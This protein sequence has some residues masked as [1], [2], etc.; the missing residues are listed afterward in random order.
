LSKIADPSSETR[1]EFSESAA[2]FSETLGK[3]S[4]IRTKFSEIRGKFS[5]IRSRPSNT[6]GELSEIVF[7]LSETLGKFSEHVSKV[8]PN[9]FQLP[10]IVSQRSE[11]VSKSSERGSKFSADRFQLPAIAFQ[12]SEN[13]SKF[14]GT[15]GELS[16]NIFQLSHVLGE[17]SPDRRQLAPDRR[18][19]SHVVSRLADNVT[20]IAPAFSLRNPVRFRFAANA[21]TRREGGLV[22]A[23]RRDGVA[24]H[25]C[26]GGATLLSAMKQLLELPRGVERLEL[27][28]AA[29][30]LVVDEDLGN[31]ALSRRGSGFLSNRRESQHATR[32][33]RDP[34]R[35]S[36]E[37]RRRPPSSRSRCRLMV[38]TTPLAA[39]RSDEGSANS[40]AVDAEALVHLRHSPRPR[41]TTSTGRLALLY[42]RDARWDSHRRPELISRWLHGGGDGIARH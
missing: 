8:S 10:A 32:A 40:W 14:E 38:R 28:G 42:R 19:L 29:D 4:E 13:V 24:E 18:R 26:H 3:F 12:L 16:E 34:R 36:R 27:V 5:P 6:L 17:L 1:T 9:R 35:I 11:N 33:P 30:R 37:A 20:E 7:R 25:R 22:I 23:H 41:S 2:S 21:D 31:R 15:L 39:R